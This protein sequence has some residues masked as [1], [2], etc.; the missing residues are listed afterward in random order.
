MDPT[1]RDSYSTDEVLECMQLGL[2]CVQENV[3]ERPTMSTIVF[4]LNTKSTTN[5]LPIPQCPRSFYDS[6]ANSNQHS[7]TA[8]SSSNSRPY[9]QNQSTNSKMN[10]RQMI[11][12]DFGVNYAARCIC[13]TSLISYYISNMNL[14]HRFPTN[15]TLNFLHVTVIFFPTLFRTVVYQWLASRIL[16]KDKKKVLYLEKFH[17][18]Q[19]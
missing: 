14:Y 9:S 12:F 11:L 1:L 13:Y 15:I 4:M 17:L 19:M 3:Q 18:E 16:E 5:T 10:P 8:N 6:D 2:S 7:A